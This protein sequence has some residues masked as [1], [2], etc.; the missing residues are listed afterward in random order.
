M[1]PACAKRCDTPVNPLE[2]RISPVQ[3]IG[4]AYDQPPPQIPPQAYLRS[5]TNFSRI[6]PATSPLGA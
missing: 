6:S 1:F 3:M 2:Q 4:E 5:G